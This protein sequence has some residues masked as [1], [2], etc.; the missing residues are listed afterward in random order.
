MNRAKHIEHDLLH[1]L[2]EYK[3]GKLYWKVRKQGRALEKEAG[4]SDSRGYRQVKINRENY[5]SHRLIYMMFHG[6][7]D[8]NLQIDHIDGDRSNNNIENLRVVTS[9][10]NQWNQT[11]AKG[12]SWMKSRRKWQARIG[13]DGKV[14][15]LGLF[16]SEEDAREAYL[17][18]KENLHAIED[19]LIQDV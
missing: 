4:S 14:K 9:Q 5:K 15:T 13:I 2:F 6:R 3:A 1:E 10:E 17:K 8:S 19:R 12:Y 16:N 7:I 18:A 11:K